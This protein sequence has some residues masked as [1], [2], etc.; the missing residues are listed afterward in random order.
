MPRYTSNCDMVIAEQFNSVENTKELV[1]CKKR[2]DSNDT[3]RLR[4]IYGF[5][6]LA[7]TKCVKHLMMQINIM[8]GVP[9]NEMKN[10]LK[11][12]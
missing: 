12:I 2:V 5:D 4:K 9:I 3:Q 11:R 1:T 8:N 6:H 7:D 10:L